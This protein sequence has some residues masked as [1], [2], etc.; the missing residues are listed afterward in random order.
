MKALVFSLALLFTVGCETVPMSTGG[1][2]SGDN[3]RYDCYTFDYPAQHVLTL[4]VAPLNSDVGMVDV[5]FHGDQLEATYVQSGLSQTWVF[6]DHLYVKVD[7]DL[8]AQYWDFRGAEE[9]ETRKP[10]AVFE[11]KKRR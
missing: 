1:D 9:G 7:P 3:V 10:E 8:D 4:P 5:I 11:C 6:E 2:S